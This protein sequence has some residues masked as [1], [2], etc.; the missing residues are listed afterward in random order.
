MKDKIGISTKRTLVSEMLPGQKFQ[1][2]RFV[3][4]DTVYW[5][6][7]GTRT[8]ARINKNT[9]EILAIFYFTKKDFGYCILE[10]KEI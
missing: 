7:R 8:I 6:K 1:F 4:E 2:S 3:T 5:Q 9:R 10:E